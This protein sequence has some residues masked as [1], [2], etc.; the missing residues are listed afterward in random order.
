[1]ATT[2][3]RN[4]LATAALRHL[5]LVQADDSPAAVDLVYVKDRYEAVLAEMADDDMVYWDDD[6]IPY[7]VFEPLMQFLAL[8][9]A[10]AY[11][12]PGTAEDIENARMTY[13]RRIRRKT[14]RKS[15]GLSVV[16]ED[17]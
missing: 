11:G 15:A 10:V 8:S 16:A 6:E 17:F 2:R 4:Q 14:G 9:C 12:V 3:T 13:M 1:M 5:G 7:I